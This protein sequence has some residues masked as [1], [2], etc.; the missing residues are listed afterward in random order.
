L[1]GC[2]FPLP[3]LA[4]GRLVETPGEISGVIDAYMNGAKT[5]LVTVDPTH[6]YRTLNSVNSSLV[7]GYDFLAAG[8]QQVAGQLAASLPSSSRQDQLI[9]L[10][11]VSPQ[12]PAAWTADQLR[13]VLF[14]A[15][16]DIM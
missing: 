4:V 1:G 10:A 14:G 13:A 3:D 2:I 6:Q 7:T 5:T 12:A 8:A 16:H 15:R 9:N 11:T